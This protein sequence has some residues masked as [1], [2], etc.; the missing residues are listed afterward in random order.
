[1]M[2]IRLVTVVKETK[3]RQFT[4]AALCMCIEGVV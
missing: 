4:C 2:L 3:L 1:M